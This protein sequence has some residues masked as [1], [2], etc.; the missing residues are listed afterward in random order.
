MKTTQHTARHTC[1]ICEERI[2]VRAGIVVL[3]N[4]T[5]IHSRCMDSEDGKKLHARYWPNCADPSH[6]DLLD[7]PMRFSS[8][9]LRRLQASKHAAIRHDL[10]PSLS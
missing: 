5:V 9:G 3:P 8:Y 1:D 4:G 10:E 7:H 6:Q 2:A